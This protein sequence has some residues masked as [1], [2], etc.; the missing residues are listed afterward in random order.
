MA[1]RVYCDGLLPQHFVVFL[2]GDDMHTAPKPPGR[3]TLKRFVE[4]DPNMPFGF[5]EDLGTYNVKG[6]AFGTLEELVERY[7][8]LEYRVLN[9]GLNGDLVT[10]K[11]FLMNE[12]ED[13][14]GSDIAG[15]DQFSIIEV[16]RA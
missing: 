9:A 16:T 7:A 5:W 6:A 1:L 15:D 4:A 14:C 3:T 12:L 10:C 8:C 2:T 11:A 13:Q